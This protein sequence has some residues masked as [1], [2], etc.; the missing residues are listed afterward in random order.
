[1]EWALPAGWQIETCN[2]LISMSRNPPEAP[3]TD[4]L[5]MRNVGERHATQKISSLLKMYTFT[6]TP[7]ATSPSSS[8][9]S[10]SLRLS[11]PISFSLSLFI[12]VGLTP[13]VPLSICLSHSFYCVQLTLSSS[14]IPLSI[15]TSLTLF[16]CAAHS[17]QQS[18]PLSIRTSLTL[19]L[20]VQLTL[21]PS[22]Y[23]SLSKPLSLCFSVCSS[24]YLPPSVPLHFSPTYLVICNLCL[25][26]GRRHF[27]QKHWSET[28]EASNTFGRY[29]C[30]VYLF[31]LRRCDVRSD[32]SCGSVS[33]LRVTAMTCP[34]KDAFIL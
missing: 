18:V 31:Y 26:A 14:P 9:L 3:E 16:L 13:P 10:L 25:G 7:S 2:Q 30:S 21:S 27:Q 23:L 11:L 4:D 12:Y 20:C 6:R 5:L 22:P 15:R 29:I 8:P 1:M 28:P 34:H 32:V 19:F 24:L 33:G 17:L